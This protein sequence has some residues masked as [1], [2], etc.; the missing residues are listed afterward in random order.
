MDAVCA[1][2]RLSD[3]ALG[4]RVPASVLLLSELRRGFRR[5]IS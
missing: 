4:G 3:R 2:E 1:G 5:P